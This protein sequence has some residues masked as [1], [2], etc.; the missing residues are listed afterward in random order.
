MGWP[1]KQVAIDEGRF[2]V[3][4]SKIAESKPPDTPVQYISNQQ[5]MA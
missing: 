2:L 1:S 3:Y 5:Q 4:W